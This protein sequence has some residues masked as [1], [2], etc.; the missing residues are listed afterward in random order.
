MK[1]QSVPVKLWLK[2]LRTTQVPQIEGSL[3][4]EH[5]GRCCL[6]I[7]CDIAV[8]EGVI[9][10]YDKDST[11][12]PEKVMTWVGLK[13]PGGQ[14]TGGNGKE[15]LWKDND[16]KDKTFKEIATIIA[17]QPKGLFKKETK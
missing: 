7:L 5:R 16:V 8:R 15:A 10:T 3:A 1:K 17:S 14:Y 4:D 12:L 2:E 11:Y 13:T 6:G 9:E